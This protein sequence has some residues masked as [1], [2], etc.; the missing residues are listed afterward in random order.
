[1]VRSV[2]N[3]FCCTAHTRCCRC[4]I[5]SCPTWTPPPPSPMRHPDVTSSEF[6]WGL[7]FLSRNHRRS[8]HDTRKAAACALSHD[9][10]KPKFSP[11]DWPVPRWLGYCSI[12]SHPGKAKTVLALVLVFSSR[13]SFFLCVVEACLRFRRNTFTCI[14]KLVLRCFPPRHLR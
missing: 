4:L 3:A 14:S 11:I 2:L 5:F 10:E 13:T 8:S 7:C 9:L 6:S 12:A 1:M